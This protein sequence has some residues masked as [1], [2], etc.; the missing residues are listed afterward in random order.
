MHL[1][2]F[3]THANEI[4]V[5]CHDCFLKML[6]SGTYVDLYEKMPEKSVLW[7]YFPDGLRGDSKFALIISKTENAWINRMMNHPND[8][9]ATMIM[10]MDTRFEKKKRHKKG[11]GSPETGLP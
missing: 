2:D 5:I 6:D 8:E 9:F 10:E 3:E 4:D 1:G 11:G 7:I